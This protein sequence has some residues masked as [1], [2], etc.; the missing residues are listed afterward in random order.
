MPNKQNQ[1]RHVNERQDD[2][3]NA[4]NITVARK[5]ENLTS[6]GKVCVFIYLS[7]KLFAHKSPPF[8]LY[9]IAHAPTLFALPH[10]TLCNARK[11]KPI[12]NDNLAACTCTNQ[13]NNGKGIET[14]ARY[15]GQEVTEPTRKMCAF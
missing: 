6:Q 13:A 9:S 12:C 15:N 14:R 1:K 11:T 5:P 3:G 10:I 4:Q 2:Q 8:F 7:G